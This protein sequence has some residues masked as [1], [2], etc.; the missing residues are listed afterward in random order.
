MIEL[1]GVLFLLTI[2]TVHQRVNHGMVAEPGRIMT[3]AT[4]AM[5]SLIVLSHLTS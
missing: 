3:L 4:L 5:W 2:L 1:I